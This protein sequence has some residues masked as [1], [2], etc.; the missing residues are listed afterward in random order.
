M[1]CIGEESGKGM[2]GFKG[3]RMC[4]LPFVNLFYSRSDWLYRLFCDGGYED[5]SVNERLAVLGSR[6]QRPHEKLDEASL[7]C[8]SST[9]EG[10]IGRFPGLPG[11]PVKLVSELFGGHNPDKER[12]K[13]G[14]KI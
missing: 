6:S 5:S 4:C 8:D 11:Q 2:I 9:G 13:S 7:I 14:S 12:V 10:E 1:E 3:H